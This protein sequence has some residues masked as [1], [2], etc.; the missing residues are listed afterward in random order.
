MKHHPHLHSSSLSLSLSLSFSLFFFSF[1]SFFFVLQ[2][3]DGL[4]LLIASVLR[5]IAIKVQQLPPWQGALAHLRVARLLLENAELFGAW[6]HSG[7]MVA[8]LEA[9]FMTK[10]SG[11]ADLDRAFPDVW[12]PQAPQD[13]SC[14]EH[15]FSTRRAFFQDQM[16]G[17]KEKQ[18]KKKAKRSRKIETKEHKRAEG[19]NR[20]NKKKDD[21]VMQFS[22]KRSF[23][24][25]FVTFLS[26]LFPLDRAA[27][28]APRFDRTVRCAP[29]ITSVPH[30]SGLARIHAGQ[31][32]RQV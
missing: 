9:L 21:G 10:F 3:E 12:W 30:V 4:G 5:E 11:V 23:S 31:E 16:R 13:A 19:M 17:P 7:Q 25:V 18:K 28:R 2:E 24:F 27:P 22:S 20:S 15:A 26:F 6:L 32:R 1:F 8:Q 29:G 14:S